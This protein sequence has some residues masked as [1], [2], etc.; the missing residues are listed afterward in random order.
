MLSRE[1]SANDIVNSSMCRIGTVCTSD[2]ADH[3]PDFLKLLVTSTYVLWW[4]SLGIASLQAPSSGYEIRVCNKS[5]KI[6]GDCPA[7]PFATTSN[8]SFALLTPLTMLRPFL[9][10]PMQSTCPLHVLIPSNRLNVYPIN[11]NAISA[12]CSSPI[13]STAARSLAELSSCG[14]SLMGK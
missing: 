8:A 4:V 2:L 1:D 5:C 10:P 11:G 7:I 14:I 12:E 3:E 6:W 13:A 9:H